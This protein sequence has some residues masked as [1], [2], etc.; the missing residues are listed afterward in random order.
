MNIISKRF[1]KV[2][3]DDLKKMDKKAV[4]IVDAFYSE[5]VPVG[6]DKKIELPLTSSI[7]LEKDKV[8]SVDV[9][10]LKRIQYAI[11][12]LSS[13]VFTTEERKDKSGKA[14][15]VY[16]VERAKELKGEYEFYEPKKNEVKRE[17]SAVTA[18]KSA[19]KKAEEQKAEA[20]KIEA[21]AKLDADFD[22]KSVAMISKLAVDFGLKVTAEQ[23]SKFEKEVLKILHRCE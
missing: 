12:T 13:L 2:A 21:E 20:E 5:S 19:Q 4:A 7:D 3:Y 8:I 6:K 9:A 22:N 18:Q 23:L 17:S 16:F 14:Y 15:N 11:F 10:T 1:P